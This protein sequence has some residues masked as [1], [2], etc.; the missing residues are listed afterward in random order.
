MI[1]SNKGVASYT[2]YT[3]YKNVPTYKDTDIAVYTAGSS[4]FATYIFVAD[5]K[6]AE[7]GPVETKNVLIALASKSDLTKDS[8]NKTGYYTYAAVVDGKITTIK[9]NADVTVD[10]E[11]ASSIETNKDGFVTKVVSAGKSTVAGVEYA[12]EVLTAGGTNY[13]LASK[14]VIYFVDLDGNIK[15]LAANDIVRDANDKAIV[16]TDKNGDVAELYIFEVKD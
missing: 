9:V 1:R 12:D 13:A 7:S 14:V 4:K 8:S 2:A 10:T 15:E 11:L 16:V 3:G 6:A 5:A